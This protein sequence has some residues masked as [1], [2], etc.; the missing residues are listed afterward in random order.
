MHIDV[1][2]DEKIVSKGILEKLKSGGGLIP[3]GGEGIGISVGGSFIPNFI[4]NLLNI[5]LLPVKHDAKFSNDILIFIHTLK[6]EIFFLDAISLIEPLNVNEMILRMQ[7]L[8][9]RFKIN[10]EKK[11]YIGNTII[12][13]EQ[14]MISYKGKEVILP[15]KEFNLLFK[16]LSY[17][18]KIFTRQQIM[19]DIWGWDS[20]SDDR[21][22]NTHINRIREK[23]IDNDDFEIITIR[24]LGYKAIK[25]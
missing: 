12:D 6:N 18:G 4:P 16:L 5:P 11:I 19:N 23:F 20:E 14:M 17:I 21:T 24:G 25:K 10:S 3:C 2:V 13:E 7:A 22:I 15:L 9:R 1:N 8:L